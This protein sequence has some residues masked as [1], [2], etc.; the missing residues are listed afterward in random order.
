MYMYLVFEDF[1]RGAVVV[2][3]SVSGIFEEANHDHGGLG[4]QRSMVYNVGNNL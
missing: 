2:E 4:C 3:I 1:V